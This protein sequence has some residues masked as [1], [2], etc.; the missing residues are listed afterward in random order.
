[1][2]QEI[3]GDC[4]ESN[5]LKIELCMDRYKLERREILSNQSNFH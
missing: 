5:I 3:H 1:M 2:K 4:K